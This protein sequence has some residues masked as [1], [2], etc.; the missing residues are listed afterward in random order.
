MSDKIPNY[1]LGQGPVYWSGQPVWHTA[2]E[3]GVVLVDPTVK[4]PV[5]VSFAGPGNA[6]TATFGGQA[7]VIIDRAPG[8]WAYASQ[9][10]VP[11]V[12]GCWT[13]RAVFGATTVLVH[14]TVVD[15]PPPPG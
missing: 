7:S 9:T 13:L 11:S 15:G 3:V 2:G 14:F 10:F 4:V 1:G 5:R 6:G 12:A 8:R